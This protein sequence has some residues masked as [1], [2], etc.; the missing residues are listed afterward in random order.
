ME[1]NHWI[2]IVPL[3]FLLILHRKQRR[4]PNPNRSKK[5]NEKILSNNWSCDNL[6][7]S[8]LFS[9]VN[10]IIGTDW[11]IEFGDERR[12]FENSLIE[13]SWI[14][15]GTFILDVFLDFSSAIVEKCRSIKHFFLCNESHWNSFSFFKLLLFFFFHLSQEKKTSRFLFALLD[16]LNWIRSARHRVAN[17]WTNKRIKYC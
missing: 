12:F 15:S 7:F 10:L 3:K 5:K 1:L 13:S 17:E 8:S 14:S 6:T 11:T 16:V 9:M 2:K 4:C